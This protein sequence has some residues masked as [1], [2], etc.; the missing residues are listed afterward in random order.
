MKVSVAEARNK[1]TQLIAAVEKGERVTVCRHGKPVVDLVRSE[2]PSQKTRRIGTLEG[3]IRFLDPDWA[4]ALT[5]AQVE[6]FL[7]G[8]DW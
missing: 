4:N 1:L 6:A 2:A 7:S 5:A 3:K 8:K